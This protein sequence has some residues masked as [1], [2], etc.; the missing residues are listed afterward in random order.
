MPTKHYDDWASGGTPVIDPHSLAKHRIL[1]H[2]VET[3]IQVLTRNPRR[4]RLTLTL[5]DGFAGGGIYRLPDRD[6]PHL[7]SPL[8]LLHAVPAAEANVNKTRRKPVTVDARFVF[9]EKDPNTVERLRGVLAEHAGDA[10]VKARPEIEQ[11][12]F[13]DKL[14][15]IIARIK[16]RGRSHRAIFILG[17]HRDP[18]YL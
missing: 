7:G 15:G 1:R 18:V 8:I 12:R 17:E 16:S 14:D 6:E 4:E 2:Y 5:V 13:E 11:G 3:Y 10:V 9:V